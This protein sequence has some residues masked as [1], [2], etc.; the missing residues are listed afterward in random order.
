VRGA[1]DTQV[2]P[3]PILPTV[4]DYYPF[5]LDALAGT[6]AERMRFAGHER[7]TRATL[8]QTDDLDYMHARYYSPVV[9][10]FLSIDPGRDW[11]AR[12]PQSWNLFSYARNNP[13]RFTDP[14]GRLA[15]LEGSTE[16]QKRTLQS[17]KDGIPVE[18]RVFVR[19]TTDKKGRTIIDTR[20]LR[21]AAS[22]ASGNLSALSSIAGSSNTFVLST[23]ATAVTTSSGTVTLGRNSMDKGIFLNQGGM[24]P[25]KDSSFVFVGGD[26]G[27]REKALT[28]AHEVRHAALFAEGKPYEHELGLFRT[29]P[30]VYSVYDPNGAV[31]NAAASAEREADAS[32]DPFSPVR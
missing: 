23:A 25:S 24:S 28:L 12:E 17:L 4:R 18:L 3:Q 21:M 6:D 9:G 1:T 32:F 27:R 13:V 14:D 20:Y 11:N 30:N 22:A 19:T 7:D 31:N 15:V 16:H 10:R 29:A 5:G 2:P 8:S 26:L